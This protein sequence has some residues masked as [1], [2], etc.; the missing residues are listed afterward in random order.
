M[1]LVCLVAACAT[2]EPTTSEQIDS[3]TV[4]GTGETVKGVDVSYYQGTIDWN[5]VKAD[6]V[7]YAFVRV[8][9]GLGFEDPKFEANWNGTRAAGIYHGA[10]Q[11]FRP[12]QDPIQQAELLLAKIGTPGPDDLP[13]VIDVEANG[14]LGPDAVATAV[15]AWVDHVS[16]ALGRA[17]IIY[18]GFF[19][20]RDQVGA[21]DMTSSPLW[22]AQYTDA[23]CPNIAP[24]WPSWAFWQFT[25]SG[26]VAG[27]SGNVDTNRFNGSH[28]QLIDFIAPRACGTVAA[29]GGTIDDSDACFTG[30]GPPAALRRVLDAGEG[31]GLVWTYATDQ[32]EENFG[33]W[34]LV[35]AEAGR[36]R[37]EVSTPAAYAHSR[38]ARYVV[39]TAL[40]GDT[41]V[42]IDQ[43]AADGFQS[44]GEFELAAGGDQFVHAGDSTGEPLADQIQIAFDAV[45]LTR[46]P[47]DDGGGGDDDGPADHSGCSST[48]NHNAS[49]VAGL[50]LVLLALSRGRRSAASRC[51]AFR[52]ACRQRS[53]ARR[54]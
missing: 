3:T 40:A 20:W 19:F 39:H 6:G 21:P 33:Q 7:E 29:D 18:T 42:T 10:Y 27:I 51:G 54:R 52:S 15:R 2:G 38:Q 23:E 14:G 1:L 53:V 12:N 30:G 41:E 49:L 34:N 47:P 25:S 32:P 45:R 24:P 8:S 36:Y 35:M 16:A 17:P 13:P 11:F 50:A 44:L 37:I 26:S 31:G 4:C 9:D 48:G 28:Q 46:I 43:T 5:A 22:H